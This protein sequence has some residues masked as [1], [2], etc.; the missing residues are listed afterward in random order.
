MCHYIV[1]NEEITKAEEEVLGDDHHFNEEQKGFIK[2][3]D[4]CCVQAY[5]GTGKTTSMVGKL[6]ILAQKNIWKNGR[7][8]CVLSH[9]NVAVDEIKKHVAKHYPAIMQYPN[10]IGTIQE[11]V[12]KFLFIPYLAELGLKIKFQEEYRYFDRQNID[13]DLSQ[14]I[15]NH[16]AKIN[17]SEDRKVAREN[18]NK[19][20]YSVYYDS[21]LLFAND[22]NND[23]S[24]FRDLATKKFP[25]ESIVSSCNK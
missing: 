9:T 2:C 20:M 13:K 10:F 5:A 8:I 4:S 3:L 24:E 7:G 12:N 6:H 25:Q 19:R 17:Y 23:I 21:G 11:F 22:K 15:N 14:R 16:I 1:T 18:F